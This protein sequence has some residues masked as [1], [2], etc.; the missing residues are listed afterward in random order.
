MDESQ[1]AGKTEKLP[2]EAR[3]SVVEPANTLIAPASAIENPPEEATADPKPE[4]T[5]P[6]DESGNFAQTGVY[7]PSPDAATIPIEP[8]DPLAQQPADRTL[9]LRGAAPARRDGH[10]DSIKGYQ[11]VGELGRGGMGVVYRARQTA[12][13]RTVALK[14][15]LA[16][17]H[18]GPDQLARFR[19][20]AEAVAQLQHPNIVQVYDI[21]E[22]DSLPFFSL[23]F[24]DGTTL[25]K[26]LAG[27]PQSLPRS[28]QMMETLARAMH[29]AH[30]RGIIHRDLKPGNVLLTKSGTPKISDFGLAKQLESDSSKTRTGTIMGTPS[31]MAP[32]QGRG[33]KQVNHLAD[34]YALGSM[35]YEM[36]CGRPTFMAP[37]ALRTNAC[38]SNLSR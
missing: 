38:L 13:N 21:G 25:E 16:G 26:E 24:V 36:I 22:Q 32:E 11:I 12:L 7:T 5:V 15:I 28:A 2:G 34:V 17:A 19:A 29:Y 14:M 37:T 10:V 31:Y 9:D 6:I 3:P 20:E 18:A 1:N 35:L 8:V 30:E 23:E 27:K 33:E 4:K